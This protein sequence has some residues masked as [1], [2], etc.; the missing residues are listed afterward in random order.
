V[1]TWFFPPGIK[2]LG[3]DV[4]DTPPSI[5][6]VKNEWSY[7]STPP[8]YLNAW[9]GNTLTIK[10]LYVGCSCNLEEDIKMCLKRHQDIQ[11]S[12]ITQ[13]I[14]KDRDEIRGSVRF[15]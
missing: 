6:C 11:Y 1:D 14:F 4:D 7:I 12:E 13:S 3:P 2:Q 9:T 15:F 5:A 8:L 10:G